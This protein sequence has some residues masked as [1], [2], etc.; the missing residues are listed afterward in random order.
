MPQDSLLKRIC[1]EKF[2]CQP[3]AFRRAASQRLQATNLL[4]ESNSFL[5]AVYLAGYVVECSLKALILERTPAAKR[6]DICLELTTGARSHNFDV[7]SGIL[8]AKGCPPPRDVM[9]ILDVLS[10]EWRTDLRYLGSIIPEREARLF[11]ER[12]RAVHRWVEGSL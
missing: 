11:L 3:W 4:L 6:P 1:Q 7:L 2:E 9:A 12:V 8:R 10:D 5:D